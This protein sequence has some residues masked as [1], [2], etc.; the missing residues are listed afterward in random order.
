[1]LEVNFYDN[2]SIPN[3]KLIFVVIAAKYKGS[4]I[5]VRHQNR[6]TWEIPGGHIEAE[7]KIEAAAARELY[8]ETGAIDFELSPVNIYSVNDGKKETFG[9]LYFADIKALGNLP[10]SEIVEVKLVDE[11]PEQQL[12]YP[13]IQPFLFKRVLDFLYVENS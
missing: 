5:V 2:D 3:D 10:D 12:T 11:L 9:Q 6:T 13:L 1:M 7:E 4:W 8:E